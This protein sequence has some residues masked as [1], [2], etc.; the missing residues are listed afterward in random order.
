M[1]DTA[2]TG[3]CGEEVYPGWPKVSGAWRPLPPYQLKSRAKTGGAWSY[4]TRRRKSKSR[5]WKVSGV[6]HLSKRS[7]RKEKRI[8]APPVAYRS[9]CQSLL[10]NESLKA[11][12]EVTGEP[13]PRCSRRARKSSNWVAPQGDRQTPSAPRSPALAWC[14]D[15]HAAS[16]PRKP[17]QCTTKLPAR[18]PTCAQS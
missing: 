18:Q 9:R 13:P 5:Q 11:A 12:S 14:S 6:L 8:S 17:T 3:R 1:G 7:E 15:G 16:S 2:H 10:V 4:Q